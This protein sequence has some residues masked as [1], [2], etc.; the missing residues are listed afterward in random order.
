MKI[1]KLSSLILLMALSFTQEEQEG[2]HRVV[3]QAGPYNFARIAVVV[4]VLI[5]VELGIVSH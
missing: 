2:A 1:L 4:V 3:L 5:C